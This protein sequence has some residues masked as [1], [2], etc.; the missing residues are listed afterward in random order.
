MAAN[1]FIRPRAGWVRLGAYLTAFVGA[2]LALNGWIFTGPAI[3]WSSRLINPS[4]APAG[5][6][7]GAVWVSLFALMAFAVWTSDRYGELSRRLSARLSILTLYMICMGWTWGFFGLQSL[8][9]G[10]YVTVLAFIVGLAALG[11]AYR[12]AKIA[13]LL[14]IP[15]QA[16]LG[17]ALALSW[18][19][20]Q[21]NA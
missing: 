1:I 19:V 18:T 13:A 10:F 6:V 9:N 12:S 8:A 5:P 17:F 11:L 21:L 3:E 15:L 16:W 7:I 2:A 14:L 20:W 4:W